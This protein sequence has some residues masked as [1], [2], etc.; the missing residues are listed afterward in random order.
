MKGGIAVIHSAPMRTKNSDVHYE[1]R[2]DSSFYYLTGFNE[3]ESIL[4]LTPDDKK[5][6]TRIFLRDKDPLKEQWDG[7]RLGV[8]A[9]AEELGVDEAFS[10]GEFSR[11]M[12]KFF[13]N[14][15]RVY[16]DMFEEPENVQKILS[17]CHKAGLKK[18]SSF[19]PSEFIHVL[20]ILGPMR[21]IK[22]KMDL[23]HLREACRINAIAHKRAMALA[24]PGL[25][26]ADIHADIFHTYR[27]HQTREAYGSIVAGG[28]NANILHYIENNQPLKDG[29]LLLIDAG[30][31]YHCM[32]S[33]VTRTFP[34]N[35]KYS[36][37]AKDLYEA[38]LSVQKACIEQVKVGNTSMGNHDLSEK[39]LATA[40]LD[41][42]I[43]DGSL[44][45]VLE[46]KTHRKY[47]PHGLGHWLGLD[48]HDVGNYRQENA[49]P[50]AFAPG[51]CLTI[52]PGLYIP[53]NDK[54]ANEKFRG[55]GIRI[56][57]DIL[58][59]EAGNENLTKDIP[60]EVSEIEQA[61]ATNVADL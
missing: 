11:T 44:D 24:E 38:V 57:D 39:L 48:V 46:Q 15:R 8:E 3:P 32:A 9:A 45:Q 55:I 28:D 41:L 33:D 49:E 43:I 26:E 36:G 47:Y 10:F 35:G 51:M 5:V 13:E 2:Q 7:K 1:Y 29:D 30:P 53:A 60:K 31:E 42:K 19:G 61:C 18:R 20:D 12:V 22:D 14:K 6:K 17:L 34:I 37:A 4:V 27:K 16:V 25:T 56:E 23:D 54:D 40:L 52:E 59:T 21:Q 58:V 50:L